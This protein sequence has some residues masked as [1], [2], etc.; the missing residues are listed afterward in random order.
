MQS[1]LCT[2]LGLGLLFLSFYSADV[3]ESGSQTPQE[4]S[5]ETR[6]E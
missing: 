2:P 1:L 4:H 6:D 5:K 3:V